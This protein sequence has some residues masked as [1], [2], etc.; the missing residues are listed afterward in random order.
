MPLPFQGESSVKKD[1]GGSKQTVVSE[2]VL[3]FHM[4][5]TPHGMK[6]H[7]KSSYQ[8]MYDEKEIRAC[9]L[10]AAGNFQ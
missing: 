7:A 9:S 4:L 1:Y 3:P 6:S 10:K 5:V 8:Q 2:R